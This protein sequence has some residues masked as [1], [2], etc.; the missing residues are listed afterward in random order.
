M[1]LSGVSRG[2]RIERPALLQLDL[3]GAGDQGVGDADRD[4]GERVPR[5]RHDRHPAAGSAP[6]GDRR[7][8]VRVLVDVPSVLRQVGRREPAL[9]PEDRL[10]PPG[11][12]ESHGD[13]GRVDRLKGAD[14]DGRTAGPGHT[15]DRPGAPRSGSLP[16]P[17]YGPHRSPRLRGFGGR[18]GSSE[19]GARGRR[20]HPVR[21]AA[22]GTPRASPHRVRPGGPERR[23]WVRSDDDRRGVRRLARVLR[24]ADRERCRR[25]SRRKRGSS[26]LP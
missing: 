18:G 15:K 12:D 14:R 19:S 17:I 24:M 20:T 26:G 1:A 25:C 22:R 3:G 5:A 8:E 21:G 2:T 16:R 6:G 11:H 7:G 10:G 23:S 4:L 13:P 9:L